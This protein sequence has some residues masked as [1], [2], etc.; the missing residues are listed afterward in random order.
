MKFINILIF[1]MGS[2]FAPW[3]VL[4]ESN[5]FFD[6]ESTISIM[7]EAPVSK[8]Q[9][10]RGADPDWMEGKVH[11]KDLGGQ[12]LTFDVQ[13]RARGDFRRDKESCTFPPYMLNFKKSQVKGT[14]FE[15]LDKV[16]IV[17]HCRE[18]P[19]SFKGYIYKEYLTYKTYNLLTDCGFKVRLLSVNYANPGRK[20]DKDVFVS[21]M[22][23]SVDNLASRLGGSEI[24]S[25]YALPSA[26][27]PEL[28][29]LAEVFQLF[30][31]NTDFSFFNGEDDCCHNSKVIQTPDGLLPIPYDFDLTGLVNVPYAVI[32]SKIPIDSLEDRYFRGMKTDETILQK[33]LKR[34]IDKKSAILELWSGNEFLSERDKHKALKFINEFYEIVE[35]PDRV[36]KEIVRRMRNT[37]KLES[38]LIKHYEKGRN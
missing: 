27:D 26:F 30:V 9:R 32:N 25:L 2:M 16:K 8:L 38:I 28:L 7:V 37:E 21:F 5:S 34:F 19:E 36:Q 24:S 11:Y 23:E 3:C 17:S 13:I 33:T 15:G 10:Q 12:P 4:A 35:D 1:C 29:C 22:I 31:G 14:D 18:K 6:S 20:P